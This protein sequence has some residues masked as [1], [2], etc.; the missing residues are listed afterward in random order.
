VIYPDNFEIKIGFDKIRSMIRENCISDLGRK[1]VDKIRFSTSINFISSA[2]GQA[3]EFV[4]VINGKKEFPSS[5]Y[6]DLS[7]EL[8]HAKIPGSYIDLESLVNLSK[9]LN[10]LNSVYRFLKSLEA[11]EFPFLIKLTD[12]IVIHSFVIDKIDS[13]LDR[14]GAVRDG[15]SPELRKIRQELKVKQAGVQG[16]MNSLLKVAK[17]EGLVEKDTTLAMRDGRLVIPI[18]VS[19]KRKIKG[20]IHDESASGKTAFV[21]PAE[22]FEIN[23]EI[24]EYVIAEQREIIKILRDVSDYIRPYIDDLLSAF[25][26]LGLVDFIRAKAMFARNIS[27]IRPAISEKAELSWKD[28]RHPLLMISHRQEKKDVVPLNIS[29]NENDRLLLISGPNAGGKSV[30]LKTVGLLQY[31]FQCGILIPMHESS[32]IGIFNDIFIDIGDE[33]SIENDLSTYSSHLMNMKFFLKNSGENTLILIDEFGTGTEPLLGGAISEALLGEFNTNACRGVITTH[34]TNLKLFAS[35]VDG[36]VNGAMLY[37]QNKLE[38]L[39]VLE[40]GK[41]G[42]SFALE[43]ARKIGLPESV[44]QQAVGKAGEKQVSVDKML[45]DLSRDKR[46]WENKRKKIRQNEKRV[47]ELIEELKSELKVS[48]KAG[49]QIIREAKAEAEKILND[50]NKVIENTIRSIKE[51]QA[52]K[53]KTNKARE[54]VTKYR[55]KFDKNSS[56]V[57]KKVD[58]KDKDVERAEKRAERLFPSHLSEKEFVEKVKKDVATEIKTGDY[59]RLKETESAGEVVDISQKEYFVA[60]GNIITSISKPKVEKISKNDY[61]K[62]TKS[63]SSSRSGMGYDLHEKRMNFKPSIDVRGKRVEEALPLIYQYIDDSITLNVGE[64]KILHGTGTGVLR[65]YIREYLNT[66]DLIS[67]YGDEHIEFGGAGITVVKFN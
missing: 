37:D 61:R 62:L 67:W 44:L 6:Y 23:N 21:E 55:E 46:Y 45:K 15:A 14:T 18:S 54:E 22:I 52:E 16:K 47:D 59:V 31:M 50:A 26:F 57:E 33:Q 17:S 29:L 36:I 43:I 34:Y 11:E 12:G 32:L 4:K 13:I 66:V 41:P 51:S 56:D 10:T 1:Y 60:F 3:E 28:S 65:Q 25:N 8:N 30:C 63:K 64:V 58:K 19:N 20:F 9:S 35:T 49:K 2:T 7:R 48:G 42:S 39:F 27:G 40:I 38:P 5:N 24:R 53:E